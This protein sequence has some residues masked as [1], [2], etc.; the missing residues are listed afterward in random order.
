M[1]TS[2]IAS[3]MGKNTRFIVYRLRGMVEKGLVKTIP[4]LQ[5]CR[6]NLYCVTELNQQSAVVVVVS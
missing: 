5:D 3:Y 2:Q 4:D 6:S 1:K